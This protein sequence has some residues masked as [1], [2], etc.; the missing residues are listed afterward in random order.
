MGCN[1]DN[2]GQKKGEVMTV[3]AA[4]SAGRI[5]AIDVAR[6]LGIVLVYHGHVVERLMYLGNGAAAVQYKFIYS[7]H[8][9]LFF[10][11]AGFIAKDWAAQGP[12]GFAKSRLAS[13]VTPFLFFN[14]LLAGLSLIAQRDFPPFPLDTARQYLDATLSTLVNL[15]VFDIP[16]WFLMCLVSIEILH[17]VFF[18]FLRSSDARIAAAIAVFYVGGYWLN[19]EYNFFQPGNLLSGNVWIMHEAVVGYAFYLIGV[20]MRRNGWFQGTGRG[21][22][23]LGIA[24]AVAVAAVVFVALTFDLNQ[25]PFIPHIP[26]VVILAGAH[27]HMLWFPLTA[28]AGTL[29]VLALARLLPPWGWMA[30]MGR[31]ALILFCLNGVVYHHVNGPLAAWLH[32]AMPGDGWAVGAFALALSAASLAL[33]VPL[34]AAF[35]RWLP[36]LVGRPTVSGPLLPRLL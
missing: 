11:L 4:P 8:M 15:P 14:A 12:G 20:L 23:A 33:A 28:V 29:G 21:A 36:Q 10:V 22:P 13:R 31:N 19:R 3:R 5:P 6:F 9:P 27:G 24:A 18:R 35:D 26:A 1:G 30:F 25:G 32:T 16:T 2:A 17:F 34:V 7:F